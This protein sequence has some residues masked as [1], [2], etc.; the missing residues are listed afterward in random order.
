MAEDC[1]E[2]GGTQPDQNQKAATSVQPI[3][4]DSG[5]GGGSGDEKA[6]QTKALDLNV[7]GKQGQRHPGTPAGQHA[8]GSFT[9]SGEEGQGGSGS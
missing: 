9:G 3:E 7:D 6:A 4:S 8:T 2:A 1:K 5:P